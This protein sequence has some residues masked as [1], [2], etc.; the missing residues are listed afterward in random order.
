M[1]TNHYPCEFCESDAGLE[2]RIITVY[3]HRGGHH[4]IFER[5]SARVCKNCGHRHF[6]WEVVEEI[7]RLMNGPETQTHTQPVP[8][9]PLTLPA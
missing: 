5:V 8:V 6:T 2:D 1:T 4:F 9:I 3:R 7:E